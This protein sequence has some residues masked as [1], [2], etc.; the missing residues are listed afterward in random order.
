MSSFFDEASLV[1]IPSGYKDQKVYSVKPLD[2]SGDLTFSRASSATR[3]ASNGLIE[4]VRTNTLTYSQDLSN[5][6]W[7]KGSLTLTSGQADPNGGTSAFLATSTGTSSVWFFQDNTGAKT[8]SIYAKAGTKSFFS[9]INGLYNN[10]AGFDLSTQTVTNAGVGSLAKIE[11]VGNGWYRCSVYVSTSF[12]MF[13]MLADISGGSMVN[14]DTMSFAFA[15]AETGDI[16]T[17]YIATTTAAVS[18]GPV[19][20][21]PRLDYLNSTCP[22]LL[23][24]PQRSNLALYSEQFGTASY[25]FANNST[26]TSNNAV[27]PDGYTNADMYTAAGNGNFL[28]ASATSTGSNTVTF[29]VFAKAGTAGQFRIREA[30]YFGTS[31]VFNLATGT[32][33]SGTGTITN[34]GNGWYRCTH[35]QAYGAGE[36][37]V[38]F[39]YDLNGAVSGTAYLWGAQAEVGAYATSYIPTLGTSVTRVA[40]TASKTGISSLIGQTEGTLFAEFNYEGVTNTA[41]G[42]RIIAISDGTSDNRI[43]LLKNPTLGTLYLFVSTGINQTSIAGTSIIGGT[44]KVA[45]AYKSGDYAVYFDGASVFTSTATGV[46]ATTAAFVGSDETGSVTPLSGGIKQALLFKTRLTN[47]QL[48]ELTTL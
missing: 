13:V 21:L 10:G 38:S 24:E 7:T 36:T 37:S 28:N 32:I 2:G 35:T 3:V 16:A 27:S 48:A 6:D 18:V 45:I 42:E 34:Y 26:I 8:F 29:S 11:S 15:Q 12:S 44:H 40:D 31:T 17:D 1:M 30:F 14:G 33:I 19:S 43:V 5:A 9:I 47:A 39:T 41:S 20:G 22:R 4:K 46:P 23:L 25:W